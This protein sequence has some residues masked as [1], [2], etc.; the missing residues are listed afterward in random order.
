[1]SRKALTLVFFAIA[2][3]GIAPAQGPPPPP[4]GPPR[5]MSMKG[6]PLSCFAKPS[7][8]DD[9]LEFFLCN[10]ISGISG[11]R[12]KAD[13]SGVIFVRDPEIALNLNMQVAR[14]TCVKKPFSVGADSDGNYYFNCEGQRLDLKDKFRV[15]S[16]ADWKKYDTYLK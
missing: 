6:L 8:E 10:G 12:K 13:P 11:V 15:A 14:N 16:K 3:A 2:A 7:F 4:P 9:G 5:F 1:M